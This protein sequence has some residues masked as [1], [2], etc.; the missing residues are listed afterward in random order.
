MKSPL[1]LL[2]L[3][4]VFA[5]EG[6]PS[7]PDPAAI[8][9]DY[10]AT[11][12]TVTEGGVTTDLLDE[13]STVSLTLRGDRTTSGSLFVPESA[14]GQDE[15]VDLAGTWEVT[16]GRVD[17]DLVADIFLRDMLL[18]VGPGRLTGDHIFAGSR[19]QIVLERIP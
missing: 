1:S 16:G 6:D 11:S 10:A 8:A 18:V 9:G 7:S 14:G 15:A 12:F 17:L 5:C 13:G 4:V 2:A 19:I 3:C